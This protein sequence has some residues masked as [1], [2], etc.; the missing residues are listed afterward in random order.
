MK[1]SWFHLMP[2]RWLPQDFR[3]RY[4]SVWVDVPN[5]LYDPV[6]GH[7]LYNEYLDM[8][9]YA[10]QLGFDAIGV[11][12]HHQNAYGMMPSPNIMAAALA[13]RCQ[14]AMLLV[15]GNSIALYNPPM[16]VAEEFAMLDVISGGRLIAGFPVGTSMD[17]NYCYGQNPATL[18]EKYREGHDLIIKAWTTREPFAW[19]GKYTKLRY[20]NLWPYP[21]PAAASARLGAGPRL[22][23]DLGL[24][25]RPRLQLQLPLVQR[26]QARQEDDGR[27]LGAAGEA[28]QPTTNP[29]SAAFFQQVCVSDT[30]A[31]AEREWW[32]HVDYFFNKCLHLYPGHIGAPGYM[33]EASMRAGIVAQVGNTG[34]NM[35]RTRRWKELC[36]QRY[37]VAGSP[38]T[39][40]QQLEELRESLR[41]GHLASGSTSARRPSS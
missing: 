25:H 11:N 35:G 12:E 34:Q 8:L 37:I 19:N 40:R 22:D 30:D 20:V 6:R 26:L 2:W 3:E 32:P 28:R 1:F 4:H 41:V 24:L 14:R 38:A 31:A 39:V 16:R 33:S 15:L 27:L 36:D 7:R 23:R 17:T 18:R 13:R 9:E 29:H 5:A 21:D 10:D